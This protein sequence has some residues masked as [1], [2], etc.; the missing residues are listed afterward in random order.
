MANLPTP[1]D[2]FVFHQCISEWLLWVRQFSEENIK[3]LLNLIGSLKTL[4]L[5]QE[6]VPVSILCFSRFVVLRYYNFVCTLIASS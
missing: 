3:N 6:S 1:L 5:L 2:S 4:Q